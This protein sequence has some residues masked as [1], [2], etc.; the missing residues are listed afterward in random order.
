MEQHTS[1]T[2]A[3]A[4][5]SGSAY[6][7]SMLDI[8]RVVTVSGLPN[9]KGVRITL[10]SNFIFNEWEAIAYSQAN[11]AVI[12]YLRYGFPVGFEGHM[13]TPSFGNHASAI[14]HP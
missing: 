12:Q 4:T 3:C 6:V 7:A 9:F 11:C 5:H 10:P 2:H 13:P 1:I 8:Y 14:N